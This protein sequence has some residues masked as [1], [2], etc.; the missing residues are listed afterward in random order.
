M[1]VQ[2]LVVFSLLFGVPVTLRCLSYDEFCVTGIHDRAKH[3]PWTN[4]WLIVPELRQCFKVNVFRSICFTN[5]TGLSWHTIATSGVRYV[6]VRITLHNPPVR[7]RR[8]FTVSKHLF[9]ICM[10]IH[11]MQKK[12]I[13][14]K[15]TLKFSHHTK[16]EK[17]TDKMAK[18][19][20]E[21]EKVYGP[22]SCRAS[23][24]W[25]GNKTN[26]TG[27]RY[28]AVLQ[29]LIKMHNFIMD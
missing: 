26:A 17:I 22:L 23:I 3:L 4:V 20:K 9:A 28:R 7:G 16:Y 14:L 10:N 15:D 2:S 12:Q 18:G 27:W 8:R 24:F 5:F 13:T 1:H 21:P 6:V 29:I 25:I 11:S 19:G